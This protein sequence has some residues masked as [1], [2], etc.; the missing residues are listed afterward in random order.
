MATRLRANYLAFA[1]EVSQTVSANIAKFK[2]KPELADSYSRIAAINALKV[3][4]VEP[5]FP[6][7]AAQFFYEAHND[8]LLSH[9]NASFGSWRPALQSLRSFMENVLASIYYLDHPIEF[10][11]WASG[12]FRLAPRELR[13]Y[14][15]EHPRLQSFNK[16]LGLK[17]A[18]DKEYGTLSKAVHA[19][20]I[21]FRMT[22]DNGKVNIADPSSSGLGQWSKRE[23]HA[24]DICVSPLCA[25]LA[26]YLDGAKLSDI[27]TALSSAVRP[28]S[29]KALKKHLNISITEAE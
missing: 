28:K 11:K 21:L 2:G 29:R 7:G 23:Q 1:D 14:L 20:N 4:I 18:L 10:E 3:D 15:S 12:D 8:V 16:D 19:S 13:A 25:V 17:A 27:R 6:P 22:A 26:P 9:V 24:V 5:H